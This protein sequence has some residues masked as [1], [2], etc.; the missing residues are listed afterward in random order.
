MKEIEELKKKILIGRN[1]KTNYW[2]L[3]YPDG[4][5]SITNFN[6]EEQAQK[7]RDKD[8]DDIFREIDS[9]F[10][11]NL[12]PTTKDLLKDRIKKLKEDLK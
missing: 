11:D 12:S 7:Q 3:Y 1:Y 8:F 6:P 9:A 4:T 5:S 2:E 10:G